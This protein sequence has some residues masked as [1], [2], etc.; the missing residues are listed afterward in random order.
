M[1]QARTKSLE[2][3]I[4]GLSPV[5]AHALASAEITDDIEIQELTREDLTELL[6]GVQHFKL[7][8]KISELLTKSKQ[9]T[10][11]PIALVLNELREFLPVDVMENALVPGG[12]LHGY[13]PIL[14]DLEKQLAKAL[15][16]IQEHIRMLE[17]YIGE[18]SM[19][20]QSSAESP[21]VDSATAGNQPSNV[22]GSDTQLQRGIRGAP[23]S[24]T[25]SGPTKPRG[26]LEK[27]HSANPPG[28]VGLKQPFA[29]SYT[30]MKSSS[31]DCSFQ[32]KQ[33]AEGW[34]KR[35]GLQNEK[36]LVKVHSRV[37]GKTLN[38]HLALMK[39]VDDLGVGLQREE[40]S[41]EDCQ[42][43]ILF[44]PV[45]SRV[46][47]DIDAAMSQVPSNRYAIL[48]VM[49]HTFD[50]NFVTS[51]RSASNYKN[52]VEVHVLFHDSV[53]LLHCQT[54]AKAVTLI[55]KALQKYNSIT[56][57]R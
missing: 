51:Q 31:V 55:H 50:P 9:D 15:N 22:A 54:N 21:L 20:A 7:R 42:V 30:D 2:E 44:C 37:C 18:Q 36:Q 17:S 6:P 57:T 47:T 34:L 13:F 38:Y 25:G 10:A 32:P 16:F 39:Q 11:T 5:A 23:Q 52:V 46:G 8:K 56:D 40:T 4:R 53:G 27:S 28:A 49:H 43:L 41:A 26:I 35:I 1:S 12:V 19:E 48:V 29:T 24:S 3:Q 14:R 33:K 45:T